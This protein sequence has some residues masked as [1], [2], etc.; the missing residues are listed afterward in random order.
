MQNDAVQKRQL[1]GYMCALAAG[2]LWGTTGPLSTALYRAGSALTDVGFW[3]LTLSVAAFLVY[4][5]FRREIFRID[6]RGLLMIGLLGGALVALFELAYPFAIRGIGVAGAATM[7]YTGPMVIAIAAHPLLGERITFSRML[8]AVF[9][10]GGVALTVTGQVDGQGITLAQDRS[11]FL[12]GLMGGGLAALSYSSTTILA[13]YIVPRYGVLR[14]LFWELVGG[15]VIVALA[16]PLSGRTPQLP[17]TLDAW[18]YIAALGFGTVYA[19]NMFFFSATERIEAAPTAV[20]A[21]IE[22]VVGALL[23]LLLLQQGLTMAGWLGLVVVVGSVSAGYLREA[24]MRYGA[25]D[26]AEAAA[27][28]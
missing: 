5:A 24:R 12:A 19:A 7:L 10:L 22:P 17:A 26:A 4:G 27:R 21:S 18:I 9:V 16:L 20:A 25:G 6:R 11:V 15:T 23:A 28:A 2:V 3:R 13:R 8:I 1:T 14:M